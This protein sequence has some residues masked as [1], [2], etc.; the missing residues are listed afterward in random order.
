MSNRA[1]WTKDLASGVPGFFQ[2]GDT[3]TDAEGNPIITGAS[4]S[5]LS[6]RFIQGLLINYATASTATVG[7][8]SCRNS[9]DTDSIELSSDVT[10]DIAGGNVANGM[11]TKTL[12]GTGAA[13][14]TTQLTGTSTAFLT[15]FGEIALTGTIVSSGAAVTGTGTKFLSEVSVG[16]LI[17]TSGLEYWRVTAVNSDTSLTLF[18][19]PTTDF[20][21]Q[22]PNKI[23]NATVAANGELKGLDRIESNTS[24]YASSAWT[25][26][27]GQS[28]TT[29]IETASRWYSVWLIKGTSGVASL[30]STQRTLLLNP[31]TGY[32]ASARRIGWLKNNSS[33]DFL[34][35]GMAEMSPG[36]R[37]TFYETTINTTTVLSNG[38]S[39]SWAEVIMDDFL[40]P[41]S[42]LAQIFN[43][44]SNDTLNTRVMS[45][46]RRNS[47]SSSQQE[48]VNNNSGTGSAGNQTMHAMLHTD[49]A[50]AIDY[51]VESGGTFGNQI[52]VIGYFD[53]V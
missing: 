33:G 6:T 35:Q 45:F 28:I 50:Q 1:P 11:D 36:V 48:L 30:F 25:T 32:T 40:P 51:M 18:A 17:G 49:A 10:V 34:E 14:G 12:S 41:T 46:R 53:S 23:E 5:G 15:E 38:N 7:S 2:S 13:S 39:T 20:S 27:S 37:Y 31:P 21:G 26:F 16:D 19:T 8:G 44:V 4:G 24:L 43:F 9:A 3:L 52:S 22:S 29:G 42:R 47:G